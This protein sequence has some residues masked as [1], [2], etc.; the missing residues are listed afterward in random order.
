MTFTSCIQRVLILTMDILL[1]LFLRDE[2]FRT[3]NHC[4]VHCKKKQETP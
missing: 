1:N 4:N 3:K 2:S